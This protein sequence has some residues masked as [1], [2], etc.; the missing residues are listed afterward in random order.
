MA[1]LDAPA[2]APTVTASPRSRALRRLWT[3]LLLVVIGGTAVA[4]GLWLSGCRWFVVETPSMAQ[5]APVGSLVV[6]APDST[7][8]VGEVVAFRPP[9]LDRVYT[10][11]VVQVL[12]DGAVR[13]RGDLN[14]AE[15]AW[16]TPAGRIVGRA[17]ALV[18]GVG[19][20]ARGL[21]LLIGGALLLWWTTGPIRRAD[22]RAAVRIAGLHLI[23]SLVLLYLHPL[24]ALN[25]LATEAAPHGVRAS[26]VSTGLLP[27]VVTTPSGR[28][29]A[30]LHDGQLAT[31]DL[32]P[33]PSGRLLV[34]ALLDL[35]PLQHV[36]L[37]G[38]TLVP[39]AILMLVGLPRPR[40]VQP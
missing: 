12:P 14:G 29:L 38:L 35:T 6:T 13:T 27:I 17:I 8:A 4:A 31:V 26:V 20:L 19:F 28:H 40:R 10:H 24:A 34:N 32:H 5:A 37:I 1:V 7:V 11:R 15:D 9:G 25:L 3:G 30:Q 22:V 18:P 16:T 36:L 33:G 2:V 39:A 21:P 23:T